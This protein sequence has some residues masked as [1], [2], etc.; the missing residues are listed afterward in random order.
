[1]VFVDPQG[2]SVGC[3]TKTA[4]TVIVLAITWSIEESIVHT[5]RGKEK[6]ATKS[7]ER[8][9]ELSS[10]WTKTEAKANA[11]RFLFFFVFGFDLLLVDT[12]AQHEDEIIGIDIKSDVDRKVRIII[13]VPFFH[14]EETTG[15]GNGV[16][17][18]VLAWLR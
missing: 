14:D 16:V 1:M 5:S 17:I 2:Y 11:G 3:S 10:S 13:V 15:G 6:T 7:R 12:I 18:I 8:S 9:L 4:A